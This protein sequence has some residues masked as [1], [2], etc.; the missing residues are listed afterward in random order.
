MY[1]HAL[2]KLQCITVDARVI[3]KIIAILI[4]GLINVIISSVI[5]PNS[6]F[7]YAI[8]IIFPNS[9]ALDY[10]IVE[11]SRLTNIAIP[12]QSFSLN[13]AINSQIN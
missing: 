4:L 12:F 8:S 9:Q 1:C 2:D 5:S 7:N 3:P 13:I 11:L 6:S 10:Y